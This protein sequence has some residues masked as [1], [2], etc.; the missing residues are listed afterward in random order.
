M[1]FSK[2]ESVGYRRVLLALAL[3][4]SVI[5]NIALV[6]FRDGSK[7][8]G[9][10]SLISEEL[11]EVII[12]QASISYEDVGEFVEKL[13]AVVGQMGQISAL[14]PPYACSQCIETSLD[15]MNQLD[16]P[17]NLMVPEGRFAET[18]P[19]VSPSITVIE[20]VA[21]DT[22]NPVCFYP[23]LV[24]VVIRDGKVVDF[25]L[26]SKDVPEAMAIFL[27]HSGSE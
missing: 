15:Q 14:I 8:C 21:P 20:Y 24:F 1:T 6:A 5:I 16:F 19:P 23:D 17:I 11:K 3:V 12:Q 27:N 9:G 10:D 25:Y 7:T 18:L 4:V 22:Q 2:K 13:D 26:H